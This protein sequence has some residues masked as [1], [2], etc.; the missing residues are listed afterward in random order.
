M[1]L[2]DRQRD[3]PP[4][5]RPGQTNINAWVSDEKMIPTRRSEDPNRQ[6]VNELDR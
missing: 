2:A 6:A 3:N 4:T 1:H 5:V